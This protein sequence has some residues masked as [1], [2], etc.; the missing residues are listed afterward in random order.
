MGFFGRLM[1]ITFILI[2]FGLFTSL[3]TAQGTQIY[4]PQ[5]AKKGYLVLLIVTSLLYLSL[6]NELAYKPLKK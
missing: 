1:P 2:C 6:K 4:F 5:L 3:N